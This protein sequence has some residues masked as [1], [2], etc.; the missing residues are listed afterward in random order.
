MEADGPDVRQPIEGRRQNVLA[1][2]LLHVVE[3]ACPV[4][5]AGYCLPHAH[6]GRIRSV[7][8]VSDVAVLEI[9]NVDDGPGAELPSI[10]GLAPGGWIEGCAIERHLDVAG[11]LRHASDDGLEDSCVRFVVVEAIRHCLS[12]GQGVYGAR[13]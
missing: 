1:G 9:E 11:G 8:H 13:F 10:E 3:P 5:R 4:D 2:V 7:D 6:R 12:H